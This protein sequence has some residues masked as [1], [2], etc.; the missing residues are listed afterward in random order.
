[1]PY[2]FLIACSDVPDKYRDTKHLEMPPT[3]AIEHHSGTVFESEADIQSKLETKEATTLS[4][5]EKLVKIVGP[6]QKPR[7]QLKAG[8][9]RSWDLVNNALRLAEIDIIENNRDQATLQVHYEADAKNKGGTVFTALG[10]LFNSDSDDKVYTISLD[11]DKTIT[12]TKIS[13][14]V[15]KN[16][17]TNKPTPDDSAILV[18][19]IHQT[20]LKDL[21]K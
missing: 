19:L 2:F 14:T 4:D 12:E 1:M 17:D 5:L 8:F 16:S 15:N 13:K 20:I 10:N 7:L 9:D 6:E 11:K 18:R 3:L 21:A